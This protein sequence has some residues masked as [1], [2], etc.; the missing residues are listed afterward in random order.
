MAIVRE[1]NRKAG[2]REP[3][4]ECGEPSSRSESN[5]GQFAG[6]L[7]TALALVAG[8]ALT[9]L[10]IL[11]LARRSEPESFGIFAALYAA[12]LSFG[13]ILDFGSSQLWTREL[14]RGKRRGHFRPWLVNRTFAQAPFVAGFTVIALVVTPSRM[15]IGATIGLALQSGSFT[16]AQ[17]ALA[18]VRAMRS[19]AL[20]IWMIAG[21]NSLMLAAALLAPESKVFEAVA[22]ASALSWVAA[23][24]LALTSTRHQMERGMRNW[25]ENPWKGSVHFGQYGLVLAAQGFTIAIIGALAG[26]AQA[27]ALAAVVQWT[28]PMYLLS[29][30]YAG[31]MFP[32]LAAATSDAAAFRLLRPLWL[33][34]ASGA[35]MCIALVAVAPRLVHTLLGAGYQDSVALLRFSALAGLPVLVG[36]PF[37]GFLQARG[38]ERWVANTTT[39]VIVLG[40]GAVALLAIP[41]GA[42]IGPLSAGLS[43]LAL[44]T[45]FFI[46]AN[47]LRSR[48]R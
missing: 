47:R 15:S 40:L 8:Q 33:V 14:A 11:I 22:I 37:A 7:G 38:H 30:A 3:R 6:T 4:S 5:F 2:W 32:T 48:I 31:Y 16:L 10:A 44:A 23:T 45:A 36:Q 24:V 41:V 28:Q 26:A 29:S 27:G 20:A 34:G 46:R 1:V 19:P 35:T 42:A 13:V 12:S 21:G 18:S 9:G 17:G 43:S 39:I 25:R